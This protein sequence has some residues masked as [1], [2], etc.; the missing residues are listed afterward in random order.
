MLAYDQGSNSLK[1]RQDYTGGSSGPMQKLNFDS[2]YFSQ[3]ISYDG[4]T[5]QTVKLSNNMVRRGDQSYTGS[6]PIYGSFVGDLEGL[7]KNATN[8]TNANKLYVTNYA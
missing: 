3:P 4:T 5:S 8:S 2:A 7:A 6:S 1:W